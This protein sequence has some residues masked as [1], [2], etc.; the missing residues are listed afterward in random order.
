MSQ[1]RSSVRPNVVVSVGT[2][3]PDRRNNSVMIGQPFPVGPSQPFSLWY[4]IQLD[5]PGADTSSGWPNSPGLTFTGG[6]AASRPPPGYLGRCRGPAVMAPHAKPD[7]ANTCRI[8][9]PIS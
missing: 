1:P 7:K 2:A 6:G 9:T 4:V 5:S 8:Q 3:K